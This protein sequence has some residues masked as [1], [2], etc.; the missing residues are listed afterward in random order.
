MDISTDLSQH[1]LKKS[2][3]RL[4]CLQYI[5]VSYQKGVCNIILLFHTAVVAFSYADLT[6]EV[7]AVLSRTNY[8]VLS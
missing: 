1:R 5:F 3:L 8:Y 7:T 2:R 6:E 4:A